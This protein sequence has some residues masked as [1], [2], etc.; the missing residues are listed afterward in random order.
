[1]TTI[2][3]EV[4]ASELAAQIEQMTD[5]DQTE[6]VEEILCRLG[7]HAY[8]AVANY[9][10]DNPAETERCPRCGVVTFRGGAKG[11]TCH[12]CRNHFGAQ[13]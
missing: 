1:M 7:A 2:R 9:L 3:L 4:C 10:R 11:T 8:L 12:K 6:V 13:S 5:A